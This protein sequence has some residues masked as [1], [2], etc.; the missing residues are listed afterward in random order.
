LGVMRGEPQMRSLQQPILDESA[1]RT[2]C[3]RMAGK[4]EVNFTIADQPGVIS[5]PPGIPFIKRSGL[6]TAQ[7]PAPL[8]DQQS[9][10]P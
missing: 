6:D 1:V 3:G 10:R 4:P 5:R 7:S 8:V 2:D 9:P